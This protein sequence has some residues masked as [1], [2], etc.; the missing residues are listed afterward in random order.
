MELTDSVV[1][2]TGAAERLGRSIAIGLAEKGCR[3]V[4][5]CHND[6]N[7]G[8]DTVSRIEKEG[9]SA[10]LVASD[11]TTMEGVEHLVRTT[12]DHYGIWDGLVNCASIFSTIPIEDVDGEIW[13]R[14]QNLHQRAPFF[15]SKELYLHRKS[16]HGKTPACVVNITDTGVRNPVP[17]RPSYYCAKTALEDQVVILGRTLAPFVR[18]NGVAPGAIIAASDEDIAYFKRL[19][20]QLPLQQLASVD[21]VVATVCFLFGNDSI[22]GQTIVVD[23]GEHLR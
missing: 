1:V 10:I 7:N 19:E 13:M 21:D 12:L 5:H 16:T 17:S 4:V 20:P 15:L 3:M 2:V 14:D 11:L 8:K 9:G 22:T 23:G 6:L 18:V